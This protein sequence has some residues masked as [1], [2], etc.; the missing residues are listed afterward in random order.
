VRRWGFDDGAFGFPFAEAFYEAGVGLDAC[1]VA[2]DV[3]KGGVVGH[4]AGA[5]EVGDDDGG[6]AGDALGWGLVGGMLL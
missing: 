3:G 1:A 6:A 5:D 4:A 2:L